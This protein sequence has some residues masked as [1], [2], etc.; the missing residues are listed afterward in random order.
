[1]HLEEKRGGQFSH[2]E[3]RFTHP[4][5]T[6]SKIL[7]PPFSGCAFNSTSISSTWCYIRSEKEREREREKREREREREERERERER[8]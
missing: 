2:T 8:E 4:W 5:C 6:P 3:P 7:T 1:M